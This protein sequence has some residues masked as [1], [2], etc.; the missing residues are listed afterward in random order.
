MDAAGSD[1]LAPA[2]LL[3]S[4]RDPEARHGAALVRLRALAGPGPLRPHW[5]A[6]VLHAEHGLPAFV[7]GAAVVADRGEADALRKDALQ[8]LLVRWWRLRSGST[9]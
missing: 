7:E 9:L 6:A 8:L 5:D 3:A 1:I 4:L 2:M